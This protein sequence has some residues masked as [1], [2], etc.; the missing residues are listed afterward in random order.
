MQTVFRMSWRMLLSVC[1]GVLLVLPLVLLLGIL[2]QP[3]VRPAEPAAARISPMLDL[4]QRAQLMTY[5][6]NCSSSAECEP[7]LG[8]FYEGRYR[9]AYC[10]DSQCTTD[11][12]CSAGQVCRKLATKE[13]GPLVRICA[14]VGPRQE[15]EN[16]FPVPSDPKNACAAALLCAGKDYWCA[17][18][19]HLGAAGECPEGFFCA[20]T[21]PEPACLPTCEKRG[22]PS[23]E[24][25]IRFR[26]GASMC[27]HVYGT[28]CQQSPCGEGNLCDPRTD[29]PQP[30]KVWLRCVPECGKD[31]SP[32]PT[33]SVCDAYECLPACDPKDPAACAEGYR[34]R[35]P[36]PDSPF[37]CRPDW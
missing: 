2:L 13:H 26:E 16:C 19:C 5:G 29:P 14:P 30:R 22:C 23:G 4:E 25:C 17:R 15:G 11:A 35:Q 36:W 1:A 8:C 27:A 34:C 12:Q 37:A 6:R 7:P 24:Q 33:G 18:P 32:C 20:D 21:T 10:T 28:N 31:H 9:H 3:E